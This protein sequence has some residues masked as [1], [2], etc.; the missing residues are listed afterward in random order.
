MP[1]DAADRNE[2]P[3]DRL[4]TIK[5]VAAYLRVS[6]AT[7]RNRMDDSGLP[8]EKIGG[9]L[10]FRREVVDRWITHQ[11]QAPAEGAA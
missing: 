9:A 5:E 1:Q 3:T 7:V 6:E 2:L 4:W 11:Q 8:Y 10:R